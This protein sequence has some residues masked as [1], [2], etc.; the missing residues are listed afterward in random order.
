VLRA[1]DRV[2]PWGMPGIAAIRNI[3]RREPTS[4]CALVR[5]DG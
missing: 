4:P 1:A 5:M 3:A 2:R